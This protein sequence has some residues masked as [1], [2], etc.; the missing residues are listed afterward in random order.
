MCGV[1]A[2]MNRADAAWRAELRAV[3]LADLMRSAVEGAP[4]KSLEVG[5]KGMQE[6]VR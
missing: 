6:S 4:E 5:V 3:T 2:V 1:H